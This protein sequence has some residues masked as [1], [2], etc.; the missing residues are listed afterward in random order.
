MLNE[1]EKHNQE[2]EERRQATEKLM[3]LPIVTSV[4]RKYSA[5]PHYHSKTSASLLSSHPPA[6]LNNGVLEAV[7]KCIKPPPD[8]GVPALNIQHELLKLLE[9]VSLCPIL[10][11][12]F[13]TKS[14]PVHPS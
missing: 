13:T 9:K 3:M 10:P 7:K 2:S 11:S 8:L 4:M 12:L 6:I 14:V 5:F 1:V